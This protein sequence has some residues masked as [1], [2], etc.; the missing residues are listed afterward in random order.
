MVAPDSVVT[1]SRWASAA[2]SA[3]SVATSFWAVS[4]VTPSWRA[5]QRAYQERLLATTS[6]PSR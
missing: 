6:V 2:R 5:V 3:M 1:A 4:G